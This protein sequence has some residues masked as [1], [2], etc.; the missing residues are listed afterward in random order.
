MRRTKG[1]EAV[2]RGKRVANTAPGKIAFQPRHQVAELPI[3]T[4]GAA[5]KTA[6]EIIILA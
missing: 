2:Y 6:A 3:V 1:G 5:K 4:V